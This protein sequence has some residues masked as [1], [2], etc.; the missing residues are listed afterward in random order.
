MKNLIIFGTGQIA[1]IFTH[2][3]EKDSD[4]KIIAYCADDKF[5][6][7]KSFNKKILV[8]ISKLKKNFNTRDF[9]IFLAIS[10]GENNLARKNKFK[11]IKKMG[12]KFANY[13]SSKSNYVSDIKHGENIAILENQSIQ[14]FV[15]IED[16]VFI[17]SGCVVGHHSLIKSHCWITS[18]ANVGGNVKIGERCFLG[19]NSTL[20]H[21]V[22]IGENSFIG[23]NCLLTRNLKK[24]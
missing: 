22:K 7:K 8:P 24:K 12:Y 21:M 20:G 9:H 1:Q 14:P 19:L 13:I 16:N 10:Y 4:Y 17:W 3:F 23:A 5:C 11:E 15:K 6:K 18:G 2:Y